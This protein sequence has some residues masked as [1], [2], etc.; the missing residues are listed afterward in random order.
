M[1]ENA[2]IERKEQLGDF[3][4]FIDRF[5][6]LVQLLS[7]KQISFALPAVDSVPDSLSLEVRGRNTVRCFKPLLQAA[8]MDV[9]DLI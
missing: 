2:L 3:C 8:V 6:N 4:R 9:D 7:R 1:T 5:S